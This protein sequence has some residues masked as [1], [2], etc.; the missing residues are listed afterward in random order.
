[1]ATGVVAFEEAQDEELTLAAALETGSS[2][3]L[4]KAILAAAA[5][6]G[7]P[8]PAATALPGQGV[9]G[10]VG[11]HMMTLASV[12]ACFT[13]RSSWPEPD[14]QWPNTARGGTRWRWAS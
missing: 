8:V 11:E 4:A 13:A 3:P 6:D 12:R 14:A 5:D 2:H 1:M 9:S 10:R 7:L